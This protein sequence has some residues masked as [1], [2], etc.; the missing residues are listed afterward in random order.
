MMASLT[1]VI[2]L[3]QAV[4]LC[5][6]KS[7]FFFDKKLETKLKQNENDLKKVGEK[8]GE[9]RLK[10]LGGMLEKSWTKIEVQTYGQTAPDRP[11]RC[12]KWDIFSL[13]HYSTLPPLVIVD[14]KV[15]SNPAGFFLGPW[16]TDSSSFATLPWSLKC[17]FSSFWELFNMILTISASST[18]LF[19]EFA[20]S[21]V[22]DWS[23]EPQGRLFFISH[24]YSY[25]Q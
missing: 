25:S 1:T 12:K 8:V 19:I 17:N 22:S 24:S 10:K 2:H 14:W 7:S 16:D 13:Q 21:K 23:A 15:K 5:W 11:F 4:Y 3:E 18:I 6:E 9:K 20:Q